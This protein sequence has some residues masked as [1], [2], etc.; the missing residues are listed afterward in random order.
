MTW[1]AFVFLIFSVLTLGSGL[2]VVTTRNLFHAALYLMLSLFGVAG[3]FVLLTAPF[4]AGVQVVVYIGAIAILIVFA[5]MLT[6]QVTQVLAPR[7]NHWI[8][9]L[10]VSGLFFVM[11]ISV[12]TPLA[13]ELGVD[14]WSAGFTQDDPADV[15]ADALTDL[16]KSLVDV[17]R[18]VL[19]FEVASVLLMAALV[20]AVLMVR[21]QEPRPER[22]ESL[23][24]AREASSEPVATGGD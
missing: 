23:A 3:L 9:A 6:P 21:P 16:G 10:V 8:A 20:G 11:L 5:I 15:P 24:A 18:Y 1:Q 12:L 22:P 13:T 19:P 17:D 2:L 14:N 4:I 7:S